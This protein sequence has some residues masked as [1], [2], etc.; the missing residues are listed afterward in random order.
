MPKD[1]SDRRS[2]DQLELL[3]ETGNGASYKVPDP[4]KDPNYLPIP[5]SFFTNLWVFGLTDIEI[6]TYLM[7]AW[8]RR[9]FPSRHL[10]EGVYVTDETRSKVFG[11][12][13]TAYRSH[14]MLHRFR[15][16]D[17]QPDPDRNYMTGRVTSFKTKYEKGRGSVR[18]WSFKLNDQALEQPALD[19][20]HQVLTT[21]NMDDL[22]RLTGPW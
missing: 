16:I 22:R 7:L 11:L 14:T 15:L 10:E 2:Y 5:K 1:S 20:I 4:A 9:R 8:L 12:T 18:P 19:T 17:R 13:R 21:P 3:S 6:A